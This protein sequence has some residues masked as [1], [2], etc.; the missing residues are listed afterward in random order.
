MGRQVSVNG[1]PVEVEDGETVR[2]LKERGRI[3]PNHQVMV[4]GA[5]GARIV[6]DV[7]VL[8]PDEGAI[9]TTPP[10]E[11]GFGGR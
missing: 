8:D 1:L 9:F 11:Y 4:R 10:W 6:R 3:P 2:A 7:E 5:S